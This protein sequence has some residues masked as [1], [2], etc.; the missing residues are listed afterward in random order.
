MSYR[1]ARI[2]MTLSEFEGYTFVVTSDK[3]RRAL[4]LHLQSFLFWP[5]KRGQSKRAVAL[6]LPQN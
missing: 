3:T 1:M 4:P 5:I 2:P 6:F